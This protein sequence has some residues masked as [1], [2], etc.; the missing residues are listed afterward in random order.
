MLFSVHVGLLSTFVRSLTKFQQY[1]SFFVY[2]SSAVFNGA[3][4]KVIVLEIIAA[5]HIV[6]Q[7]LYN[8]TTPS[9]ARLC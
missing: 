8:Y 5:T 3:H 2:L 6:I 9:E 1:L 7:Q 4:D